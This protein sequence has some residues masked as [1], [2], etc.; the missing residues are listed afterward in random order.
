MLDDGRD[1][2]KVRGSGSHSKKDS[3][4]RSYSPPTHANHFNQLSNK[5]SQIVQNLQE[6]NHQKDKETIDPLNQ[7]NNQESD[8]N[9]RIA[10]DS[11]E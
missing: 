1:F 8:H 3:K 4:R 5:G 7:I 10:N 2:V 9:G 11:R 6:L